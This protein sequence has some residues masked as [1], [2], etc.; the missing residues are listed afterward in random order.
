MKRFWP[1]FVIAAGILILACGVLYAHFS[2]DVIYER[3][4]PMEA[5]DHQH[6]AAVFMTFLYL[7]F[8][9][10]LVG[11]VVSLIRWFRPSGIK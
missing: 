5:A 6:H 1:L 3:P 10:V 2:A 11:T 9:T 8:G 7:G 4:T